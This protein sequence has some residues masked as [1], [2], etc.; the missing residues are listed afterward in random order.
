MSK[1]KKYQDIESLVIKFGTGFLFDKSPDG[2]VMFLDYQL[3]GFVEDIYP[4]SPRRRYSIVS[5]GGVAMHAYRYGLEIPADPH[6]KARFS[7]MGWGWLWVEFAKRFEK[8]GIK[9]SQGLLTYAD[10]NRVRR[11]ENLLLN[12]NAFFKEGTVSIFNEQ[13]L[14][15]LE[16]IGYRR[17]KLGFG[18]NDILSAKWTYLIDA[19]LLLMV[20]R[21]VEG[22]GTGGGKSKDIARKKLAEKGTPMVILNYSYKRD[23]S[24]IFKPV[25]RKLF[26]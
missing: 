7:S 5:S 12:Q 17:K 2:K 15:T 11:R 8:H 13:D 14:L 20:S 19:D 23:T 16:E 18:D 4:L 9:C 3:D 24:G 21:P 26:E 6:E 25:I 10:L 1:M 22:L